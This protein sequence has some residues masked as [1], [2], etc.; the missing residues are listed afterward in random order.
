MWKA[1]CEAPPGK[2]RTVKSARALR[3]KRIVCSSWLR[4]EPK[5]APNRPEIQRPR[6]NRP[7]PWPKRESERAVRAAKKIFR[8]NKKGYSLWHF[9]QHRLEVKVKAPGV[10]AEAAKKADVRADG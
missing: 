6:L 4:R 10:R 2:P 9:H 7:P 3:W 1:V 5:K 8:F